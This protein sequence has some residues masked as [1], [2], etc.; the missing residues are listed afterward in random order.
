MCGRYKLD[1]DWTE[2]VRL[3]RLDP[4]LE[5]DWSPA[6]NIPP[7][8]RVLVVLPGFEAT[9]MRWG[10][11]QVW[12]A[13]EGK[14]PWRSA[15]LINAKFE[16]AAG[17]RTWAAAWRDRR[18]LV[19]MSGFYEWEKRG[20]ER[21]PF[22]FTP[23]VPCAFAGLWGAFDGPEGPVSCVAILTSAPNEVVAPVHDRMPVMLPEESWEAWLAEGLP[24]EVAPLAAGR[25]VRTPLSPQAGLF[26]QSP[27]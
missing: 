3:Y 25:L 7:T 4:A 10:W 24:L 16:E 19:P 17:K 22:L 8:E 6:S 20:K 23:T 14:D 18:C 11:P 27:R 12:L 15:P 2:I 13:R 5:L 9:R 26:A 1:L 21:V